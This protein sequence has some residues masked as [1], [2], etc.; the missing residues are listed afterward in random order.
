MKLESVGGADKVTIKK[1][2]YTIKNE[3]QAC[4]KLAIPKRPISELFEIQT[5]TCSRARLPGTRQ[6][7]TRSSG[8]GISDTAVG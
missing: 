1:E 4:K 2:K 8:G 3:G 5:R 7:G 6:G